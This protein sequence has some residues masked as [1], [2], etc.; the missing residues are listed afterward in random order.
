MARRNP[1]SYN[2]KFDW[3]YRDMDEVAAVVNA[4]NKVDNPFR[5]LPLLANAILA[6][7]ARRLPHVGAMREYP[8]EVS[9]V[10]EVWALSYLCGASSDRKSET[11]AAKKIMS[12]MRSA[13]PAERALYLAC[14][15]CESHWEEFFN[16][17][18]WGDKTHSGGGTNRQA[19]AKDCKN[20]PDMADAVGSEW[21][22][23][24]FI[25][26]TTADL[27]RGA[28]RDLETEPSFF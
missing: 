25:A 15:Y 8:P 1:G 13:V 27:L 20:L 16:L 21:D 11:A 17:R 7:E 3:N 26:Y 6:S 22:V 5:V 28:M 14:A 23:D 24:E 9:P 4:L 10:A 2:R 12:A 19:F 18:A